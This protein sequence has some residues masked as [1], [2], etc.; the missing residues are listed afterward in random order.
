LLVD[1]THSLLSHLTLHSLHSL[2]LLLLLHWLLNSLLHPLL[3]LLPLHA[4]QLLL[5]PRRGS[6][7]GRWGSRH[8]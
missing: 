1:S 4:S 5:N 6:R 2:L 7:W 8:A 3:L